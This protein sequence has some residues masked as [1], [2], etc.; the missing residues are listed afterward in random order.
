MSP[1]QA[2]G[3]AVVLDERT[4][5]YS[6]GVTLYELLTLRRAL[7]G[8]SREE[9][10]HQ[11]S[12]IDP[13]A[14]RSIDR[15]IPRELEIIFGKAMAKDPADRYQTAR[16]IAEDLERFLRD[17]PIHARP[18]S[19]WDRMVKWTRRHRSLAITALLMLSLAALGLMTSTV[20]IAREQ[21]R[22]R[23]AYELEQ[24][25]S[26][27]ADVQR[28]RAHHN[29][30][31]ARQA[32]DA[33]ARIAEQDMSDDPA[34]LNSRRELLETALGYY[35]S[36]LQHQAQ[37]PATAADLAA[38]QEQITAI[39]D[40]LTASEDFAQI[41]SRITLLSDHN[42]WRELVLSNSQI[43]Q[44]VKLQTEITTQIPSIRP[45]TPDQRRE[46]YQDLAL[47]ADA[48]LADILSPAQY[49][50]LHQV[51]RQVRGPYA[52][53]DPEIVGKLGLTADQKAA[54]RDILLAHRDAR[55]ANPSPTDRPEPPEARENAYARTVARILERLTPAQ[56][57]IWS[58]LVGERYR[59]RHLPPGGRGGRGPG[60]P[61]DFDTGG[62][63]GRPPFDLPPR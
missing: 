45:L 54:V 60:W 1:E 55:L 13:P 26:H 44:C 33:F 23:A 3:K 46:R 63:G 11:L 25:R 12:S 36:F 35:Q 30:I 39:L 49:T 5:I 16:A 43:D 34:A 48:A 8:K 32:V 6:L 40:E 21:A 10:L 52:F 59:I 47:T 18:P 53:T 4:D 62:R 27:E 38:A 51:A 9:L 42:V 61:D 14:P 19:T 17:Q 2:S 58:S 37:D 24:Q 57:E 31:E 29:F 50:R 56:R 41:L 28:A 7:L 20:L 22:T 15:R